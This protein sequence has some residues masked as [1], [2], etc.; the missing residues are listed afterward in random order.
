MR[1]R[2]MHAYPEHINNS[3][4]KQLLL[5]MFDETRMCA[6]V[7]PWPNLHVT[8]VVGTLH[9]WSWICNQAILD[10]QNNWDRP[11]GNGSSG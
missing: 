5:Y 3:K 6:L 2:T 9:T 7:L 10:G 8:T 4:K 11:N 1:I